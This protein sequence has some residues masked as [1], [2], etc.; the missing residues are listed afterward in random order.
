MQLSLLYLNNLEILLS[1][2]ITHIRAQIASFLRLCSS[3][4]STR[5]LNENEMYKT[6]TNLFIN[7]NKLL[8]PVYQ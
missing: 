5:Y 6:N 2:K 8:H 1:Y 3:F 7:I 4:N